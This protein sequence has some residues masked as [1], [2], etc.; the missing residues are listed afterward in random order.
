MCVLR[1]SGY[2]F[3]VDSF[4]AKSHLKTGE[5]FHR[6]E[7]LFARNPNGRKNKLSGLTIYISDAEWSNLPAQVMD[8]V[9]FLKRNQK[10]LLRLGQF[11]GVKK[12]CLDFPIDLRIGQKDTK[13]GQMVAAQYDSFPAALVRFAGAV[14]LE[15]EFSIYA[16]GPGKWWQRLRSPVGPFK[17]K[18]K[19]KAQ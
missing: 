18:K 11:P 3:K 4:M 1:A 13:S 17:K 10:E 9:R 12:F 16:N 8:A 15:L 6:G 14:N 19:L 7:P 5:V 2:N